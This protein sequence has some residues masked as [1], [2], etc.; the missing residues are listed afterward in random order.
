VEIQKFPWVAS[1][2]AVA[3]DRRDGLTKVLADPKTH[4]ILGMGIV[5]PGA[6]EMI[7]ESTLAVEMAATVEDIALT[8]HAHPTLSETVM[9]TAEMFHGESTHI[10]KPK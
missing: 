1:G 9:E 6:G 5:G 3:M 4:R 2:R 8:I 10:Y 7:A